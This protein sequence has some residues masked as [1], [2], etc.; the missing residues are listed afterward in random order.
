MFLFFFLLQGL[1]AFDVDP[2]SIVINSEDIPSPLLALVNINTP[3]DRVR[4]TVDG[5]LLGYEK[6][7]GNLSPGPHLITVSAPDYYPAQFP[8]IVQPNKR[9]II[10]IRLRPYTGFLS[11]G[12]NP[13]DA[14]VFVDGNRM[15]GSLLELPIGRYRVLVRK[16]GFNEF[17]T[18]VAI[19]WRN[20]S[21]L[22]AQLEPAVFEVRSYRVKPEKFNPANKAFY[23]QSSLLFSVTAPGFGSV[24]IRDANDAVVYTEALPAFHTWSQRFVWRGKDDKGL[25]L[26]DG[27][28]TL[29]LSLWPSIS[30]ADKAAA[31]AQQDPGAKEEPDD[32]NKPPLAFMT[33]LQIDSTRLITPAGNSAARP[34]LLY[35][36]NPRV[37][38]LLPGSIEFVGSLPL[39]SPVFP[40]GSISLGFKIGDSLMLSAE[41]VFDRA[42]GG[43]VSGGFLQN[44]ISS[45]GFDIALMGRLSWNSAAVPTYPGSGSEAELA[46]PLAL[47]AGG[48]RAGLAPGLIYDLDKGLFLPRA[49]AGLWFADPGINAGLSAQM[50]F[51]GSPLLSPG[52]PLKAAAEARFLFDRSPFTL[53]LRLSGQFE[54]ELRNPAASLGLGLVW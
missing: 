13:P 23:N 45:G 39:E 26:P 2:A 19:L 41:G 5:I 50:T 7:A 54:P 20:T 42:P 10:T 48:F 37:K 51:D 38:E 43:G 16:F 3:Q 47:A 49:S 25:P 53:F 9:Y 6:W 18:S 35:F 36:A 12:V 8:I 17:V 29:K 15:Y 46:L 1:A 52:N 34:G 27:K 31:A 4:I 30:E 24:E 28:Y 33:T 21:T 14:E 22:N 40:G 32:P 44:I 11:I